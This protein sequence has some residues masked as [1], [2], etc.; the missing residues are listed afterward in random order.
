MFKRIDRFAK[1]PDYNSKYS[2]RLIYPEIMQNTTRFIA[3]NS[4]MG[5]SYQEKIEALLDRGMPPHHIG[6]L[7]N[8]P[9]NM[10]EELEQ[11]C[12]FIDTGFYRNKSGGNERLYSDLIQGIMVLLQLG[13]WASAQEEYI[14]ILRMNP[15]YYLALIGMGMTND[16]LGNK[17]QAV[18][19]YLRAYDIDSFHWNQEAKRLG[20]RF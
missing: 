12:G 11:K 10:K 17:N 14:D 5:P 1:I 3:V 4:I 7:L 15:T 20:S 18:E 2:G 16:K 8:I 19:W 13:S 6:L 9:E